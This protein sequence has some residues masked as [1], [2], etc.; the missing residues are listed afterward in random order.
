M[1]IAEF[2]LETEKVFKAIQYDSWDAVDNACELLKQLYKKS[3]KNLIADFVLL[4]YKVRDL[5]CSLDIARGSVKS[6]QD[7]NEYQRKLNQQLANAID[8]MRVLM[9]RM[10]VPV[11]KGDKN[12]VDRRT[13]R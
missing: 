12:S 6:A 13:R 1:T 4:T 8:G 11:F 7:E 5:E 9:A 2:R 3:P 10:T